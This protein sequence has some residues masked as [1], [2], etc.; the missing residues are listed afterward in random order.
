MKKMIVIIGAVLFGLPS[1]GETPKDTVNKFTVNICDSTPQIQDAIQKQVGS[2]SCDKIP[3]EKFKEAFP[4]AM[5][6]INRNKAQQAQSFEAAVDEALSKL[7]VNIC[8]NTP[9][10][11]DAIQKASGLS[12]C[13][14][15]LKE[16]DKILVTLKKLGEALVTVDICD[17]TLQVKDA[18]RKQVGSSPCDKILLKKLRAIQTL[19][20][21]SS[22]ITSLK[23]HDFMYLSNLKALFLKNN[24]LSSLPAGVFIGPSNLRELYL[25]GNQL[26]SLPKGV[27]ERLSSLRVLDLSGNHPYS[28]TFRYIDRW[29]NKN[30]LPL[31]PEIFAGLSNLRALGLH[32]NK[33]SSLPEGVFDGLSKLKYLHLD[34]NYISDLPEGLFDGLSNL[35][36][37]GLNLNLLSSSSFPDK[38]F[39]DLKNIEKISL[40]S[41]RTEALPHKIVKYLPNP[42][43][44]SFD[45]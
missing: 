31:S 11:Q 35:R 4:K 10:A 30:P 44:L 40:Y 8:D 25:E 22:S 5:V 7:T 13:D 32:D 14:I 41:N 28:H 37:L 6:D 23:S 34:M 2:S 17:R 45:L 39:V 3:M 26:V 12:L 1:L 20:L 33:I 36:E 19:D 9:P 24:Q 18:I 21:S 29:V 15:P 43:A 38:I 16:L 42:K 27:F